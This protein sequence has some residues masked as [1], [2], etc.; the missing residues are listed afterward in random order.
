MEN[1]YIVIILILFIGT[2]VL[3]LSIRNKKEKKEKFNE[4][5]Q[6]LMPP[7]EHYPVLVSGYNDNQD[8]KI[9][10]D[11][12]YDAANNELGLNNG[13]GF[14]NGPSTSLFGG[15][16]GDI[17]YQT[18]ENKT[19]FIKPGN[20]NT[21]LT[22]GTSNISPNWKS[23]TLL[24]NS[25]NILPKG[26]TGDQGAKGPIG[27]KG[28]TGPK[29]RI[30]L[31]GMVGDTGPKGLKGDTG[32]NGTFTFG[33]LS[34]SI[35]SILAG[36]NTTLGYEFSLTPNVTSANITNSLKYNYNEGNSN[37]LLTYI[38]YRNPSSILAESLG[39]SSVQKTSD[40]KIKVF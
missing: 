8:G 15:N 11:F 27:P 10:L 5:T 34:T 13:D 19:G 18:K 3:F 20:S 17:A 14:F 23:P 21:V 1:K 12:V 16:T 9:D 30:G 38:G 35:N 36:N 39:Y 22:G 37:Q 28:D 26:P 6:V 40:N 31:I 24:A 29:G 4:I 7:D 25:E 32:S 2:L 33:N